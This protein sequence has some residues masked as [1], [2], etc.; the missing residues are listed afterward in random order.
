MSLRLLTRSILLLFAFLFGSLLSLQHHLVAQTITV[1]SF[2]SEQGLSTDDV[3]DIHEDRFGYKW[4]S[5]GHG[6]N[7]FDGY[8][9]EVFRHNPQDAYSLQANSQG[10]L[11]EDLQ[12]NIW[13]TL[14]IG[15]VN[16]YDRASRRFFFYNYDSQKPED[17][18][19]FVTTMIF[20]T[21]SRAWVGTSEGI[22]LIDEETRKFIPVSVL[23][24]KEVNVISVFESG[25][26]DVWMTASEGLFLYNA[27]EGQFKPILYQEAPIINGT[28]LV[29]IDK[30]LWLATFD[31]GLYHISLSDK[32][33]A[34]VDIDLKGTFIT[35]LFRRNDNALIISLS[36]KGAYEL[37]D[38]NKL[39]SL[40]NGLEEERFLV[41]H[42]NSK[43]HDLLII[44]M[45]NEALMLRAN[46]SLESLWRSNYIFSSLYLGDLENGLWLGS[47]GGGIIQASNN[48]DYFELVNWKGEDRLG[49]SKYATIVGKSSEGEIYLT[50]T[51][52]LIA[53][54][55]VTKNPIS[56]FEYAAKSFDQSIT[57]VWDNQDDILIGTR[58][59][60]YRLG[61]KTRTLEKAADLKVSGGILDF[62]YDNKGDL[63]TINDE[64][65][66]KQTKDEFVDLK[67]L[68]SAPQ[69][70]KSATGRRLFV[71]S[72]Q[73]IW[74]AT[75]RE[76]M[77]RIIEHNGSYEI[78][79][80][81][82]SGIRVSGFQSQTV[83]DVFEDSQG[84]LWV[85]GF[86]SGLIEFDRKNEEWITHTPQG[87]MPIPN[88]QSIQEAD[89]GVLW[90]SSINGLHS[91]RPDQ[92]QFKHYTNRN[93]LPGNT[94]RLQS[95]IKTHSGKLFFGS[96]KGITYFDPMEVKDQM[97][98]P[99][100]QIESVRLF[101]EL[102]Q[103]EAPI[104][105]VDE[106]EFRYNQNFIG[107]D[108]IAIDYLN[109]NDIVYSYMLEGVD[110]TW[111]NSTKL[112]SVNYAS[113]S[114]GSYT[115]KVRAGRDSGDWGPNEKTLII[116]ILSPFWQRWWFYSIVF[117]LVC[118][119]LYG[120]HHFR[121]QQK[122]QRLSFMESIRKK[123]AA[124]FHDEMGNKLTRIALFSEVLERQMNG[125]NP[126]ATAYVQKIKHNSRNLNNSM[127]DFLWALDPKKDSAYDLATMLKDFGEELFDKTTIAFSADQIPTDLQ[128]IN[129]TMDWKRHLIM[130]FKEAMHNVLKH[131]DAENVSLSFKY[132]NDQLE[133]LL[134][135]D[136]Q[137][138]DLGG[139][140]E[141]YGIRN[142][143]SRVKELGAEIE[144][145]TTIGSGTKIRFEGKP[146]II[147]S[148]S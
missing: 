142:M 145:D 40:T 117:V 25:N 46:G 81:K 57:M 130:T 58:D 128:G 88:I 106:L 26:G 124:D 19:N 39:K 105:E 109:P 121:V 47:R 9:F 110:D 16:K 80:F 143:R 62:L 85:G 134:L 41:A 68:E 5:T 107:F 28:K 141:G 102:V 11:F 97:T 31:N 86:S 140:H 70:F 44:T 138:F 132:E 129:L 137:G 139:H 23:G 22:N 49:S 98:Y 38:G 64:R 133:I 60:F 94:F 3:R 90:I 146:S 147:E 136:G 111:S 20:D 27:S 112:R 92:R 51:K 118:S 89:N 18:N 30:E 148:K 42:G 67:Q 53:L 91:Y 87:S 77:F 96:T 144:I 93:G 131:S 15:G 52:A 113:L 34:K 32:Q 84:R 6:L 71:D 66:V 12:G 100:V 115:F 2:T 135:D 24:S 56:V 73:T 114:P 99:N 7:K 122:I 59:G 72:E 21:H 126:D 125:S 74:F 127:R 123:A 103:K 104:Q 43:N 37:V 65:L 33:V 61:K 14:D 69:Q 79:Q 17:Q 63:W 45:N 50:T 76:G 120:I 83:N 35:N 75:V 95:S 36:Q 101:D 4:I 108:F 13:V 78:K 54:D 48:L 1:Q 8:N 116:N 29:E 82:Y 10:K 119:V 55:P